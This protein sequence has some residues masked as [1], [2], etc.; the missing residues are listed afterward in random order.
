MFGRDVYFPKSLSNIE[1]YLLKKNKYFVK[2][3]GNNL[4]AHCYIVG[5]SLGEITFTY[6]CL[7]A[8]CISYFVS[9]LFLCAWLIFCQDT[10]LFL[11]DCSHSLYI[12]DLYYPLSYIL[13]NFPHMSFPFQFQLKVFSHR[14]FLCVNPDNLFLYIEQSLPLFLCL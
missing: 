12:V 5:I 7:L 8:T 13:K 4:G 14:M 11:I 6:V 3:V 1:H 10:N 9:F 2:M